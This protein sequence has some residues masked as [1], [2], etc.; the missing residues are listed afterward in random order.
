MT[1]QCDFHK[2]NLPASVWWYAAVNRV[3]DADGRTVYVAIIR[4]LKR[5]AV[6]VKI[7]K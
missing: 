1:L 5:V 4:F 6:S 3:A 7:K 2:P